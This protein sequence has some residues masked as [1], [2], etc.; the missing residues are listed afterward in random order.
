MRRTVAVVTAL[1]L[2]AEAVGVVLLNLVLSEVTGNQ[3]MSLAGMDPEAMS[4]GTLV[5]GF[6]SGA[7]LL[8]C[9]LTAL[10]AAVRDRA[11]G[12]AGR[13]ALIVC[14]VVHGVLG[15]AVAALV[16]WSAFALMM[17]VLA[18]LVLTLVVYGAGD[19]GPRPTEPAPEPGAPAAA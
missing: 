11:P 4:D 17:A 8:L 5:M 7:L 18:L 14:A 9:G 6:V 13:F 16:N 3:N 19:R 1:V 2:F 12:R 10:V 15:A